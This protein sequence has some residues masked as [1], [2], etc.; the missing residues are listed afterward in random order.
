M[1]K[2]ERP[3]SWPYLGAG[4]PPLAEPVGRTLR[5]GVFHI[6]RSPEVGTHTE[7]VRNLHI[8]TTF[9]P[10]NSLR[11]TNLQ[12]VQILEI[13]VRWFTPLLLVSDAPAPPT[14]PH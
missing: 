12:F 6:G 9:T 14:R 13:T 7:S 5:S 4:A 3:A 1:L 11:I 8:C 2:T 10:R